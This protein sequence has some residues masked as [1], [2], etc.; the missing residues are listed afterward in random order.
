MIKHL[1][2]FRH[3]RNNAVHLALTRADGTTLELGPAPDGRL[4]G[5]FE[6]S[7]PVA[8]LEDL[9]GSHT[10]EADP[11][12]LQLLPPIE[13]QEVWAAGVTYLRSKSARM[14]ESDFSASAYDRVYEAERPELFFK[15]L[16]PKV[17]GPGKPVGIRAD[18][19]WNVPEPELAL[20]L[21]SRG[22]VVAYTIGNDMSSRDI[23]GANLLYLPQAKTYSRSCALGPCLVLGVTE[24]EARDWTIQLD[25]QRNQT[26]LFHGQTSVGLIR[27]SFAEL[28]EFLFRCQSFPH[29]AV[30]LT[31]TGIVPPNDFSLAQGDVVRISISGIGTLENPVVQV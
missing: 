23:E 16:A 28:T 6:A 24:V 14:D 21:N 8:V 1:K 19:R 27:R 10:V 4:T 12:A 26:S 29:G 9:A 15:S 30:L 17:V 11:T 20:V 22:A 7:D 13:D 25:I 5:L 31:G 2:L 18:S 3:S